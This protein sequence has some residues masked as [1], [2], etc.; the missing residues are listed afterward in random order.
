MSFDLG[1]ASIEQW[2][3]DFLFLIGAPVTATNVG[4]IVQWSN[5]E[6]GGGRFNPL[7]TTEGGFGGTNLPGNSAGVKN[8]PTYESGLDAN[9]Q[10]FVSGLRNHGYQ[11]ILDALMAQDQAAA[12]RAINQSPWGTHDL[13]NGNGTE[14]GPTYTAAAGTPN[15]EAQLNAQVAQAQAVTAGTSSGNS[16]DSECLLKLPGIT[17]PSI[18]PNI[19]GG[20]ILSRSQGRALLGAV[21][22]VGGL[23]LLIVGLAFVFSSTK[24]GGQI[25]G[26]VP[27][28]ASLV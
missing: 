8:Y 24:A 10:A 3:T 12:F 7:N 25:I 18:I 19:G 16:A 4:T 14:A 9:V 28:V 23:G 17:M 26:A 15:P 6:G 22:V 2:A 5:G 21:S 20:C 27:A 13:P 11:H 1:G